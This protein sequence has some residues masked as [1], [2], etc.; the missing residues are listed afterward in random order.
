MMFKFLSACFLLVIVAVEAAPSKLD[1]SITLAIRSSPPL[2]GSGG[3]PL[4]YSSREASMDGAVEDAKLV[5]LEET[6]DVQA[7]PKSP[8]TCKKK[9]IRGRAVD[10]DCN[11]KSWT[12]WI[13]CTNG[14]R[15]SVGPWKG[16]RTFKAMCPEGAGTV[17]DAGVY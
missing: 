6:M 14:E 5:P 3:P 15:Y 8:V 9:E 4:K 13:R 7:N 12:L 2:G 11:G 10:F 16:Q 17:T 1:P